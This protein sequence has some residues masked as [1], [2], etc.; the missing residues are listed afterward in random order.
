MAAGVD[1]PPRSA[2]YGVVG[3]AR[4]PR[5]VAGEQAAP[6][7]IELL[8]DSRS[9]AI[10]DVAVTIQL[11]GYQAL[12]QRLV[13]SRLADVEAAGRA[14]FASYRGPLVRPTLAALANAVANAQDVGNGASLQRSGRGPAGST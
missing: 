12:L 13:G 10:I 8:I 4:L 1:A 5:T 11:P 3:T 14:L 9:G 7:M 2:S 6:L